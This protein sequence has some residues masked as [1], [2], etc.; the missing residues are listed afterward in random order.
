VPVIADMGSQARTLLF[1]NFFDIEYFPLV[2]EETVLCI[3][4][5]VF[6]GVA[7]IRRLEKAKAIAEI[8]RLRYPLGKTAKLLLE[9]SVSYGHLTSNV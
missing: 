8:Q 7:S 3:F 4:A 9:D 6:D 2:S 1:F 5:L